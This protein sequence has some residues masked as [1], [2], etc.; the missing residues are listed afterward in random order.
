MHIMKKCIFMSSL[1]CVSILLSGC[2]D[3]NIKEFEKKS[4]DNG[5]WEVVE[6]QTITEEGLPPIYLESDGKLTNNVLELYMNQIKST[7]SYLF[8]NCQ[9]IYLQTNQT[10]NEDYFNT[11]GSID[12]EG[13]TGFADTTNGL[14][15]VDYTFNEGDVTRILWHE[16]WH[17]YDFSHGAPY[18]CV[19]DTPSWQILY[20][21]APSSITEYG[22][23]SASE[24]FADAGWMYL[25]DKEELMQK[26]EDVYNFF[27]SLPKE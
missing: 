3:F 2:S 22:A 1:L 25:D 18:S 9:G 5:R 6:S 7:P 8:N 11:F 17:L 27:E 16:L 26:N 14:V 13:I 15:H 23:T 24:F 21:E 12:D 20:N 19:Q 10:V 4:F